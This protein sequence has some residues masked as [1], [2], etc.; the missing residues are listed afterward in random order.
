[1]LQETR[2]RRSQ[3]CL[4]LLPGNRLQKSERWI[5]VRFGEVHK[6]SNHVA[7]IALGELRLEKVEVIGQ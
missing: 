5:I 4:D 1:M 2:H 6:A 7:D 3:V